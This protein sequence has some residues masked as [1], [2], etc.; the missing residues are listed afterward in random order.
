[1]Y[2]YISIWLG[3]SVVV[4]SLALYRKA[5]L[6][7]GM[8]LAFSDPEF[9]IARYEEAFAQRLK[10]I[11]RWVRAVAMGCPGAVFGHVMLRFSWQLVHGTATWQVIRSVVER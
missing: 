7:N 2:L 4:L 11:D 3:A 1:M 8:A 6:R 5:L 10:S 9:D